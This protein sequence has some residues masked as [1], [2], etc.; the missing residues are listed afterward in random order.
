MSPIVVTGP[1][2][3]TGFSVVI[4]PDDTPLDISDG[5]SYRL[6][7][8]IGLPDWPL[9]SVYAGS[10][11]TYGSLPASRHMYDNGELTIPLRIYGTSAANLQTQIGQV[12][13]KVA[14]LNRAE[15]H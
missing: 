12:R 10:F 5:S 9:K 7:D 4:D 15:Q 13:K 11:D 2:I 3:S 8:Q 1:T 14:K 6:R